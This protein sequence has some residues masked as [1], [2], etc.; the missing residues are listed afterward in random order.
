[1]AVAHTIIALVVFILFLVYLGFQ[2]LISILELF[3]NGIFLYAIFLRAYAELA[4]EK[5]FDFYLGGAVISMAFYLIFGNPF[6]GFYVWDITSFIFFTFFFAQVVMLVHREYSKR[7][8][9][10]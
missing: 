10:K 2:F 3:I 5:K 4:K 8:R 7:G 1:M 9:R 6:S